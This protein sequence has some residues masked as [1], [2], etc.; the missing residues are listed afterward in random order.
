MNLIEISNKYPTEL[1]AIKHFES[2]RCN[3]T[4]T[5]P[6]FKSKNI[7]SRNID[8]HYH[9]KDCQKYFS[10]S[11]GTKIHNTRLEL[12]TW[13]YVFSLIT[14]AKKDYQHYKYKGT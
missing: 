5:C 14:D 13:L 7:G 8:Y 1:E 6:Y 11:T 2:V 4:I 3:K 10:V 12:K 9:C